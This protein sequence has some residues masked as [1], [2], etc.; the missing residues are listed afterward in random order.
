MDNLTSHKVNG[1]VDPIIAAGASIIY[2][3]PYSP[4]FN[5]I[6]MMWSKIKAYLRKIKARTKDFLEIAIAEALSHVTTSDILAWFTENGYS[7]H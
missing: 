1:A 6:E 7:T 5:P 3:P 4:D 2:L